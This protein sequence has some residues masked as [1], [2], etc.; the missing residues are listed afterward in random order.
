MS[1]LNQMFGWIEKREEAG[2]YAATLQQGD[3]FWS[4][5]KSKDDGGDRFF[6]RAIVHALQMTEGHVWLRQRNGI[7]VLRSY[8]QGSVGSC[9]GNGKA[10]EK[11][12]RAALDVFVDGQPERFEGMFSAEWE[13]YASRKQAGFLRGG[14]GS[15]GYGAAMA[16]TNDGA[17][18]YGLVPGI[19]AYDTSRCKKWGRGDVP[20]DAVKMAS[21]RKNKEYLSVDSDEK[22]WLA[23]GFGLPFAICSNQGFGSVR[24][25]DGALYPSG[26][27]MH[28]MCGGSARRT[29]SIG[30]KLI[31]IHQ[32]WGDD[33][34]SGPYYDDQPLGSFYAD[35]SVVASMCK[36]G[37][38]FVSIDYQ[39]KI[40][41]RMDSSFAKM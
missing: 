13:Y 1:E 24:D 16:S 19:S 6:Y 9:V 5:L 39:G 11:S 7:D 2:V 3:D 27:W 15:T 22:V 31:L 35:L 28:C 26:R 14:D 29:T 12:I 10:M 40:E 32:S 4:D 34:A 17:L 37:D 20:T 8:N 36:Q 18:P 41:D 25:S 23:A 30:R 38:T 21:E 33:W